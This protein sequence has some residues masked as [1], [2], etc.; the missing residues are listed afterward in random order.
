M[1]KIFSIFILGALVLTGCSNEDDHF[2]LRSDDELKL[3]CSG[4]AKNFSVCT[5][6]AWSITTKSNWLAFDKMEGTGDGAIREQILVSAKRNVSAARIDSFILHAAGKDLKVFVNQ[7]EGKSF[8][9]GNASLTETLQSGV[10]V[11]GTVI[12]VPYTYGYNGMKLILTTELSGDGAEG[13]SVSQLDTILTETDGMLEIPIKGIPANKGDLN[14]KISVDDPS[15]VPV[16]VKTAVMG[17]I[18]LKQYFDLCTWGS[19]IVANKPGVKGGYM[20]TPEGYVIDPSVAVKPTNTTDDGGAD[21]FKAFAPSF[22]ASRGLTG[23]SGLEVHEHP[24]YV[25]MG[26]GKVNGYLT[27]PPFGFAPRS[28]FVTV[29]CRAAQYWGSNGTGLAIKV[30]GGTPSIAEYAYKHEG[31]KQGQVW[32][33]VS[34]TITGVTADTKITF[35]TVN[36]TR[37]CLDDIVVS[38]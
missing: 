28:G 18:I 38:E 14:I 4:D 26:T 9:M 34:F 13:L 24:G 2:V 35:T 16:T 25:K 10:D 33:D 15:V 30:D 8:T 6:G 36:G 3:D 1:K 37:F 7:A 12:K 23:W 27:T 22:I 21:I 11:V 5:D 29:T 31:T 19:D 17:R 32:E 20:E